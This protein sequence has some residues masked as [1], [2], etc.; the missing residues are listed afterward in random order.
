MIEHYHHLL[1]GWRF[2]EFLCLKVILMSV[3]ISKLICKKMVRNTPE[4]F[5]REGVKSQFDKY[6]LD[7]ILADLLILELFWHV[8]H[9]RELRIDWI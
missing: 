6:V 9:I 4:L 3:L 1:N 5:Y 8:S 2:T 7:Y